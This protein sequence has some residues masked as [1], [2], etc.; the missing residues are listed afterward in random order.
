[1]VLLLVNTDQSQNMDL[2]LAKW[3]AMFN[4]ARM[5]TNSMIEVNFRQ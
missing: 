5:K 4:H 2:V 3:L 1:M